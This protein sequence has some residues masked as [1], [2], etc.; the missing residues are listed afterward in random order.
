M[1]SKTKIVKG[2]VSM[3]EVTTRDGRKVVT[4][5]CEKVLRQYV[6]W[7]ETPKSWSNARAAELAFVCEMAL[8]LKKAYSKLK[9][10]VKKL[11]QYEQLCKKVAALPSEN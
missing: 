2:T 4:V 8:D 6:K 1:S 5:D 7:G 10:R 3:Q 9:R 11:E